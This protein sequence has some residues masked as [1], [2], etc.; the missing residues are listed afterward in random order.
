MGHRVPADHRR[1]WGRW[2]LSLNPIIG[3]P[4]AGDDA[5]KPDLLATK[6]SFDVAESWAIGIETYS[7]FGQFGNFLPWDEQTHRLFAVVDASWPW[8]G[9][10]FGVGY[11]TGPEKWIVKAIFEI[12]P[13]E[14]PPSP[15]PRRASACQPW[16]ATISWPV[17]AALGGG[18]VDRQLGDVFQG[19]ELAVHRSSQHHLLHHLL[20]ADAERLRLARGSAS[21]PGVRTKPGQMTLVR[22]PIFALP[23]PPPGPDPE[24]MLRGDVGG[25]Q[26]RGLHAVHAPHVEE[27]PALARGL[28]VP[29]RRAGEEEACRGMDRTRR[30]S[31]SANS[32]MG[33][34]L[35]AG[36]TATSSRPSDRAAS[37]TP[38][39]T[40]PRR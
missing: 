19:G 34:T 17:N 14:K 13:P 12:S 31:E 24:A 3:F 28:P 32:V 10:N 11:G 20:L 33:A 23:S 40:C 4:L 27:E 30:Q 26:R 37:A 6:V 29:H 39:S 38:R 7:A 1:R 22:T 25:L 35:H 21:P 16:L 2:Y 9:L 5:W 8:F 18:E 36:A 15:P